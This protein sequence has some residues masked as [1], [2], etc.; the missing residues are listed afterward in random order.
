MGIIEVVVK[1]ITEWR[2]LKIYAVQFYKRERKKE[3][4][5]SSQFINIIAL[6]DEI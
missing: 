1:N 2:Q 6:N 5:E 4:D 3:G